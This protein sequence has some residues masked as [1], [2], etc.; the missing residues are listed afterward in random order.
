MLVRDEGSKYRCEYKCEYKVDAI[1]EQ[2]VMREAQGT[3][4]RLRERQRERERERERER[5]APES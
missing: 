4:F 2:A 3:R 1:K 5:K